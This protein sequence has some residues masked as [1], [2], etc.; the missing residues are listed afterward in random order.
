[1][2]YVIV[3][4]GYGLI[5]S[6]F[7]NLYFWFDEEE[8]V[9]LRLILENG[10]PPWDF[11]VHTTTFKKFIISFFAIGTIAVLLEEYLIIKKKEQIV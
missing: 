6:F 7:F 11:L 5:G 4:L 2:R 9:F 3:F 8:G 1:M 10:L